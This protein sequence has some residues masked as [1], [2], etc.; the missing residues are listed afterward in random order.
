MLD[1]CQL[2]AGTLAWAE[3]I[4]DFGG[5]SNGL[6]DLAALSLRDKL[7]KGAA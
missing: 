1:S 5:Y 3:E 4:H 2:Y 6:S 7:V